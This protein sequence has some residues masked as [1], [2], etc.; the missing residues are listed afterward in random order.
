MDKLKNYFASVGIAEPDGATGAF[1]LMVA[2]KYKTKTQCPKG[3]K[4]MEAN[5]AF[6]FMCSLEVDDFE[7]IRTTARSH[8]SSRTPSTSGDTREDPDAISASNQDETLDL[9]L[10]GNNGTQ[11][12][13]VPKVLILNPDG[14]IKQDGKRP[15][16]CK[17]TRVGQA[18]ELEDCKL[19]HPTLCRLAAC[20]PKRDFKCKLWHGYNTST[21][22]NKDTQSG[23]SR[24]GRGPPHS[25]NNKNP[26]GNYQPR[27]LGLR[28]LQYPSRSNN[29]NNDAIRAL[30][31]ELELSETRRKMDKLLAKS[32]KPGRPQPPPMPTSQPP[33][34]PV[35]LSQPLTLPTQATPDPALVSAVVAAVL[36]AMGQSQH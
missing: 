30:K 12:S 11:E 5:L 25:S 13:L 6:S 29:N 18:C 35:S 4:S 34:W 21:R 1:L 33:A 2:N 9:E 32:M 22:T 16:M 3:I 20:K 17:K 15:A 36:L 7:A 31:A 26:K 8:V 28:D 10:N 19:W 27:G 14:N 23:N 24:G